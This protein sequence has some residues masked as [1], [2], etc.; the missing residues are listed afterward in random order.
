MC[1]RSFMFTKVILTCLNRFIR[2]RVVYVKAFYMRLVQENSVLFFAAVSVKEKSLLR[3]IYQSKIQIEH[4]HYMRVL[5]L[6][7]HCI[8]ALRNDAKNGGCLWFI[9]PA[10][11]RSTEFKYHY[12]WIVNFNLFDGRNIRRKLLYGNTG[13]EIW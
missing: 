2:M 1:M 6:T 10:L 7:A 3:I 9:F 12:L 4:R 11:V 5:V 13:F 8:I